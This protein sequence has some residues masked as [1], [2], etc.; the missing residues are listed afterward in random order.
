MPSIACVNGMFSAPEEARVPI[1]DRGY[2][3]GDG[4]YETMRCYQGRVWALDRHLVRLERSLREIA[5]P[6][7]LIPSIREWIDE[8]ARRSGLWD[9]LVY[10]QVTR[11][12]AP[13]QHT[14]SSD[15]IPNVVM[16]M[17]ATAGVSEVDRASG[18]R[19][20]TLPDQRWERRDIKSINLLPN[21]LAKQRAHDAGAFEAILVEPDGRVTEGSSTNVFAVF[22]DTLQTAPSDHHI[23]GG[24]TRD[25][26]LGLARREGIPVQETVFNID[27]LRSAREIFLSGTTTEALGV[28][29]LDGSP[30]ADGAVGPIT[31]RLFAAFEECVRG[32]C[33]G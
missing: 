27:Q 11:G 4:V 22:G 12:V 16:T 19:A 1:E 15:L 25:L 9:A 24:I 29:T 14:F 13:R 2:L 10:V 5:I 26:V 28:T 17:R 8:G 31:R 30:V 20:I 3:F 21:I 6:T 33:D 7:A 32:G 23:L 18:V